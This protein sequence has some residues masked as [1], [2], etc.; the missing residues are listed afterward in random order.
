MQ[1]F[2][3]QYGYIGLFVISVL[4]SACLPVPS[5]VAF[6]L[7]GAYC[8]TAFAAHP[9]FTVLN[10]VIIGTI[11]SVV[12]SVIAYELGRNAGRTIVDRYGKWILL[13]HKDLDA[14]EV[15]FQ[16]YGAASVFLGRLIPVVRAF[17]SLPAGVA[18]MKRGRFIVLTTIG[19]ALWVWILTELGDTAGKN[20]HFIKYFHDAEYPIIA[21]IVLVLVAGVWHR[22]HS[23]KKPARH[24]RGRD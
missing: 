4:S 3:S 14:S 21:L 19:C 7:A 9:Q 11:G 16:K 10:V 24:A 1:H 6:G 23:M 13:S 5:E 18:E 17:I 12:G 15:W 20:Q 8:T 2:I 22:W